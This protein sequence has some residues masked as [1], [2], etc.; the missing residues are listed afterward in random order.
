MVVI[1]RME[2]QNAHTWMSLTFGYLQKLMRVNILRV[3]ILVEYC[4]AYVLSIISWWQI[5]L[6]EEGGK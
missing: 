6:M 4:T 3:N 1:L 5:T 2:S